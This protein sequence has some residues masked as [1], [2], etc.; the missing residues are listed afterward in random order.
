MI[1]KTTIIADLIKLH[2]GIPV[3][4]KASGMHCLGCPSSQKET[5]EEACLVHGIDADALV[6]QLNHYLSLTSEC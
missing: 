4:L 2:E 1:S 6:N 3:L 5:L